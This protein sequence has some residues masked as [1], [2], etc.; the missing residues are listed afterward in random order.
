[1][2]KLSFWI[3]LFATLAIADMGPVHK[4]LRAYAM[5][6]AF[7]A[8]VDDQDAVYYNP[9]GLNL[10]NRLGNYESYPEYGYYPRNFID[11]RI[12]FGLDVPLT[13][14]WDAYKLGTQ[15]QSLYSNAVH[16]SNAKGSSTNALIDSLGAHP[17]LSDKL[18]SFDQVPINIASKLDFEAAC[19]HFGGAIWVDG[20][21]SPYI[22]TGIITPSA[23]IDTAYIDAVAQA[24]FAFGI[25]DQWSIGIGGQASKRE[26]MPNL[27]V[28]LMD[29]KSAQDSLTTR[30]NQITKDATKFSTIGFA[31][32]LGVLYQWQRDVR[33]GASLRNWYLKP[34]GDEKITPNLTVGVDYSPRRLQRNTGFYRKV[35]LAMDFEDMLNNDRGYKPLS[36]LDFGMEI[37]QVVLGIPNWPSLRLL[38]LHGGVGFKGGYPTAGLG[39]EVLRIFEIDATTWADETGYYTGAQENR[40]WVMQLSIGI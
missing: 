26:Y 23:G 5:G 30:T 7:V 13:Q 11:A 33:F 22:E 27:S 28:S 6:N 14:A 39:I 3:L 36:H 32:D 38:K 15:I 24:A 21:V 29:W 31:A 9:A 19:P 35:N 40:Y 18:N 25:G 37:D 2:R 1:M 12:N 20:G 10:I 34:M 17:E 8:V 4:T 16:A